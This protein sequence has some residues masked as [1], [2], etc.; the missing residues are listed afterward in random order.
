[1]GPDASGTGG[2]TGTVSCGTLGEI[3]IMP[4]QFHSFA[5]LALVAGG[6]CHGDVVINE[7]QSSNNS[8]LLD[9]DGDAS[10]WIELL[11][12]GA[13][14]VELAGW[15]LSDRTDNPFKW[16]LPEVGL[17]PGQRLIVWCSGKNRD[18]SG[19]TPAYTT[20]ADVPGLVL[21]LK[22][23]GEPYTDGQS[24]DTWTDLSGMENHAAA[25]SAPT[26]PV[27]R[28]NRINGK[29]AF[30]FTRTSS[31]EFRLPVK[32]F[33][34][35]ERLNNMTI[36]MV[37]KW[38]GG[39]VP[40]GL[41]GLWNSGTSFPNTHF[42]V[43]SGGALRLRIAQM[44]SVN[45]AS[46][47]VADE[48]TVLT[49]T[50]ATGDLPF[51]RLYKDGAEIGFRTQNPGDAFIADKDFMA[52][53]ASNPS[54][55][56]NG[57]IAEILLFDR[58][59]NTSERA[60]LD[61]HLGTRYALPGA[62]GA[63]GPQL[64]TSFSI[65]AAG[66]NLV[67]TRPDGTTGDLVNAVAVPQDASYGR[68]PEN[69][70]LFRW[71][72][73]PTP[74]AANSTSAYDAP[75]AKPAFSE[76]RGF[77]Q[78]DFQLAISHPDPAATIRYT[79]DGSEPSPSNG[80]IYTA[81]FAVSQTGVVRAAAF[82]TGT[83]PTRAISTHS[84]IFLDD[85]IAQ[86]T[87]PAG[88]PATWG[89]FTHV[90]YSIDSG[91]AAQPGY[92][93]NMMAALENF[94]TLSISIPVGDMFGST[95]LYAN[96]LSRGLE[97]IVSAEW[98]T[99]D[100]GYD[101][102]IDAGLRIQGGASREPN[103]TP[104]KSMRLLFKGIYG[105]GRLRVP[106]LADGGTVLADFNSLILRSD[107]N[108]SWLHWDAPQRLRGS[109]VRD[110]WMRDSQIAMS[111]HG[112]HG[113]HVHLYINGRYWGLYNAAE[114]ADAAFSASYFGGAREDYDA[115]TH[116]GVRDGNNIAWNAMRA[117]TQAGL[118]TPAQYDAIRQYLDVTQFA[119][120]MILNIYGGN[121]DWPHNNW[122]AARK[123][124]PGAGY[125]FFAWDAERSLE[126]TAQNIV[127]LTGSN[128]PA[129]FYAA[130]RQNAEFRLHFADRVHRHFFNGGAL[131]PG[132]A[133]ARYSA[134]ADK[135]QAGVFAE[136]ARWGAYRNQIHD[137]N[138]P[139]PVY[140][141][142]PHWLAERDRLLNT[143]F[144][145]RTANVLAQFQAASLYPNVAAPSF[146]QHGGQLPGSQT[147]TITAPGGTIHYTLDG[148]DP[149]QEI[150]SAVSPGAIQYTGPVTISGQQTLKARVLDGGVWS[151]LNEADFFTLMPESL[152]LPAGSGDWTLN[153]NWSPSPWPDGPAKRAA[154]NAPLTADRNINLRAPVTVGSIRFDET[155]NLWRN[156][157]RD[158]ATGNTLTI[159]N[160]IQDALFKVD[161]NGSG[162]VEFEVA[163]GT[164]LASNLELQV[165]HL[166]GNAEHGALRLRETWSGP[167]GLRKTGHGIASLTG[168]N[169]NFSGPLAVEEGV[170]QL[171]EPS[172]PASAAGISVSPG[173]QLRLVSG[174]SPGTPRVYGFTTPLILA[175]QGRSAAVPDDSGQGKLGALRY[176][177]G[178]GENHAVIPTAVT[179]AAA[180][181]IHVDG[182][183]NRLELSA[184]LTP[185][186]FPFSKSGGGTLHLS[187]ENPG[188][189]APV[190]VNTGS[191]QITGSLG[192]P[193]TLG[194]SATLTGH[195]G[196]G[197]VSG[198]GFINPGRKIISAPTLS[199]SGVTVTLGQAGSPDYALPATDG[200]GLLAVG[201]IATPPASCR[202]HL[203]NTGG[204]GYRGL[205]FA[206]WEVDLAA[207]IHAADCE[208]LVPDGGAWIPATDAQVLT[209]PETANFGSGPVQGRIVE[210]RLGAAPASFRRWQ[211]AVYPDISD[212]GII[213][214]SANPQG[215][216]VSN[217]LRYALGIT[218]SENPAGKLPQLTLNAGTREFRFPFDPGRDDIDCLV[219]SSEDLGDWSDPAILFNS[220]HNP[221]TGLQD[222]WMRIGIPE[223]ES[224]RLFF[225]LHVIRRNFQAD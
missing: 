67:L 121:T 151:A 143:Y 210:V 87:A 223:S 61:G 58:A 117:I 111:G 201:G 118:S 160:G 167:G 219:E 222:G 20:P 113:N 62:S 4:P 193:V 8:T 180:A 54:R 5:L 31:Q 221:P 122:N 42:E 35:M 131:T 39:G 72:A 50:M 185:V 218:G 65:D 17:D 55:N 145:V 92:A 46:T 213:G 134:R 47:V 2:L 171:T 197:P 49:G 129:E 21:W 206:P 155:D 64:H 195:G 196:V 102:Q 80:G 97:K 9:E 108:N 191:L 183:L 66:E 178:N 135:V 142:D 79:T 93:E 166:E 175:G 77:K 90:S 109:M 29:P 208:V 30:Q 126:G 152:F 101:T 76:P 124:E 209:V 22:A 182:S 3:Q 177:P 147:I 192:S 99:P 52:I 224:P 59:L 137:R 138:G 173:G 18:T 144:P 84:Y 215:D 57:D 33:N 165:N 194:P 95:G 6:L 225:R 28:T 168:E 98:I 136:H 211:Q 200:N 19:E 158:Q 10:D 202:I 120:Y 112:S 139:S 13:T 48:W 40:S 174:S 123:R 220:R 53:G 24:A 27:F 51:A 75:L 162:Y 37:A 32:S 70:N 104:K 86:T 83:L 157:V 198:G 205:I 89:G 71:F 7:F 188:F 164:T 73:T 146:S 11:N 115:M 216:G 204:T 116:R 69:G 154:I 184:P 38:A 203:A 141:V 153:A 187:A 133:G 60:F 41:F 44:D 148:S 107:Y 212:P 106:V 179:L 128:N 96:P 130:L 163:A 114:R 81:P 36:Y 169:K 74:G 189:T 127:N 181:A 88:Y 150:T 15:G 85:V 68:S 91:I 110:Q 125:R 119:D 103:N 161:G 56:L 105:D 94:P 43:N 172:T 34:G 16:V 12:R 23:E 190:H 63:N 14:R 170:L 26:R 207:A 186:E 159:D 45:V 199:G 156:R 214:A 78:S 1:M 149:R 25:P 140:A 82:K 100:G 217:L 176:V 132:A